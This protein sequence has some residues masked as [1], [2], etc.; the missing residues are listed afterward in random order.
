VASDVLTRKPA[1]LTPAS[2]GAVVESHVISAAYQPLVDL[3]DGETAGFEA[4]ARGPRGSNIEFPDDL[5]ADALAAGLELEVEW[6]CQRAALEGA[7]AEGLAEGQCLFI[8]FNP[9]L[10]GTPRP[11]WLNRLLGEALDRFPVFAELT[12]R[13]LTAH[14][15]DLL[16]AVEGLRELGLGIAIDDVGA[17][18]RSLALMPL[19]SPDVIKLDLHLVKENPSAMV[20]EIVHAINAE[21]ERTGALV[22]AE[23]IETDAH[24]RTAMA[25]GARYGQGW[26]FGHPT[27]LAAPGASP[28]NQIP[29][30]TLS[31]SHSPATPFTIA[32]AGRETRVGD[33]RLLRALTVEIE[34]MAASLGSSAVILSTFQELAYFSGPPRAR[35]IDLAERAALVGALGVGLSD[36][37]ARGVRGASFSRSDPLR[38]EWDVVLIAPHFSVALVARDLGD[39][40][41]ESSRRFEFAV[42]YERNLAIDS[43]RSLVKRLVSA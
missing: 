1:A 23:G 18:P 5:F 39:N 24:L 4:L 32:A 40:C 16:A 10:L 31:S 6:E 36:T 8:N 27:E 22:L 7:L 11:A 42:T 34:E 43:A 3:R 19:L 12:E 38:G 30:P 28:A 14:P 25:L 29:R 17:D 9:Q 33:K 35:Y 21:S 26:L 15:A 37:P 20:A 41:N 13:S 2:I